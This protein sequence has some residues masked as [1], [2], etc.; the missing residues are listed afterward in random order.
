[1]KSA[2]SLLTNFGG[3]L[4]EEIR[5]GWRTV[6]A[7]GGPGA[8]DSGDY[9][10]DSLYPFVGV[11]GALKLSAVHACVFLRAE[12]VA[13]MP[14]HIR[15]TKKNIVTDH[16]LYY[17]LHD[18]PNYDQTNVE[19]TSADIVKTDMLGNAYSL[20]DRR[21]DKTVRALTPI[22]MDTGVVMAVSDK[23]RVSYN[24]NGEDYDS[25]EVLH[26]K[27]FSLDGYTGL[28]RLQTGR[29][30]LSAQVT[31]DDTAMRTFKNQLKIGGFFKVPPTQQP[32]DEIKFNQ[33]QNRMRAYND[34]VN[35]NR[36][37]PLPPGWEPMNGSNFRITMA[38][39][40]VLASRYFGIEEICRLFNIPPPL[41][42]HTDKASSWA[43]SVEALN[44]HFLMYS[45][46][47]T[48]IRREKRYAM[49]LLSAD[50]RRKFFPR[51]SAE[52]LLRVDTKSRYMF[53]ASGLQ[54][55]W[56]SINEV[57]DME[58]R[59][60][61]GAYGDEFRVQLNMAQASQEGQSDNAT[62]GK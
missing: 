18:S 60:S 33:F 16:D 32:L 12:S 40:E 42:G 17:L 29:R 20:I 41:I 26:Q 4:F 10:S 45:L 25:E 30:I 36:W 28:S 31:A 2:L 9:G 43:S 50:E 49:Q 44:M 58:D 57:R 54:N 37:M 46:A 39:A 61:I 7:P 51:Y 34:P 47:P 22:P 15:D 8:F 53:Y 1:M 14:L 52:G 27:G 35:Q 21:R 11:G 13:S 55:G 48:L 62:A 56:L 19:Y 24:I 6:G 3:A 38:D 23:G 59:I 5:G